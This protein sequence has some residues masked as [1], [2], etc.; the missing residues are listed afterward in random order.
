MKI[1]IDSDVV[2]AHGLTQSQFYLMMYLSQ[3]ASE[4][5]IQDLINNKYYLSSKGLGEASIP[6]NYHLS[7]K[8][9][10]EL[11]RVFLESNKVGPKANQRLDD[12]AIKIKDLFPE[13]KKPG[14]NFYWR[15]NVPEIKQKL[16]VFFK[17]YGDYTDEDVLDATK[18]YLEAHRIDSRYM[19][20]CKYFIWKQ[21]A[22]KEVKSE[23][24]SYLENKNGKDEV[25]DITSLI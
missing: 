16:L 7:D 12:L 11:N 1:T 15:S 18:R 8:G 6:H 17:K 3:E 23:L 19:Q 5:E 14:T 13:G 20:L 21:D 25:F 2:A 4:E 24:L 10:I 22:N 9:I